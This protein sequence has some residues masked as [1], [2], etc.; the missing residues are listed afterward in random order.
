LHPGQGYLLYRSWNSSSW[1]FQS[2]LRA[3]VVSQEVHQ[4]LGDVAPLPDWGDDRG[5]T[6]AEWCLS[7]PACEVT[8]LIEVVVESTLDLDL[9]D[10]LEL[11]V[12]TD[13]RP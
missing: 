1:R 12:D 6:D 3:K 13:R 5:G 9:S 10:D 8:E 4:Y 2:Y 11:V 7:L